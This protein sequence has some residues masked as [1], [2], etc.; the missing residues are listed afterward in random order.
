[1]K[2]LPDSRAACKYRS[3]LPCLCDGTSDSAVMRP[4]ISLI[5]WNE[6]LVRAS[7]LVLT[8]SFVGQPGRLPLVAAIV[9][10]LQ[11]ESR[12]FRALG[13][14]SMFSKKTALV[15]A[16]LVAGIGAMA[17]SAQAGHDRN[18]RDQVREV[19]DRGRSHGRGRDHDRRRECAPPPRCEPR[20]E[21]RRG[22]G[23]RIE[24]RVPRVIIIGGDRGRGRGGCR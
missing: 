21:A 16:A 18:D 19:R 9:L 17:P 1:M 3:E 7:K 15:A 10:E 8:N 13:L 20:R 2:A 11:K 12:M 24:V 4:S 14:S 6:V 23:M 22:R 5:S